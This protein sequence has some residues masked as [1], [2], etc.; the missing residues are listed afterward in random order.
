MLCV[1][2]HRLTSHVQS[3]YCHAPFY[4]ANVQAIIP[5]PTSRLNH[6]IFLEPHPGLSFKANFERFISKVQ[7]QRSGGQ[8]LAHE[9]QSEEPRIILD[10]N[11]LKGG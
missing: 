2:F 1:G 8:V 7:S 5:S 9:K 11:S 6:L 4:V 10:V 3:D